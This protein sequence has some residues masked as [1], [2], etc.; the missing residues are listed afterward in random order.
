[1]GFN[2]LSD[3][4]EVHHIYLVLKKQIMERLYLNSIFSFAYG[5]DCCYFQCWFVARYS[6]FVIRKGKVFLENNQ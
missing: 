4:I 2:I 1:M 5:W 3:Y 6:L